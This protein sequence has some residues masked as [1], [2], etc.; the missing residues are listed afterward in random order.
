MD[1]VHLRGDVRQV[2]R[3]LNR[4]VAAANNRDFLVTVEET[5]AGGAGRDAAAFE[6]LFRR[7]AQ[8]AGRRAGRHDQRIAG[9]LAAIAGQAERTV[10]QIDLADVVKQN[11]G[12]KL[13]SVLVH[14]LHQQ[15]PRQIVRVARPVFYF[16]S[17]SQLAAFFHTGNQYR[18][19]VSACG[20]DRS[21][22]AGRSR[23]KNKQLRMFSCAHEIPI[24]G[25]RDCCWQTMSR[26]VGNLRR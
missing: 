9:V 14:T 11:F 20:I 2:E 18:L 8:V 15:R 25:G 5:V 10:L 1:Q 17:G 16:G 24:V 4:R 22:V 12:L 19:K 6:C 7:Q 13:R 23:T 26:I 3:F 21:G